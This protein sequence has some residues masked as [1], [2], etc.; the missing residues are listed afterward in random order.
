M[1]RLTRNKAAEMLGVSRQTINNYVKEGLLGGYKDEKGNFYVNGDDVERY[2]KKYKFIAAS[3]KMLDDKLAS[4][5]A[6][7]EKASNELAAFRRKMTGRV[8]NYPSLESDFAGMI[9]TLYKAAFVPKLC[10]RE[11]QLL[12]SFIKGE[13]LKELSEEYGLTF[14]RIRQIIAKACRKFHSQAEEICH[15]MRS[16]EELEL[17]VSRLEQ[18]LELLQG[19]YDAYREA[20]EDSASVSLQPP[21]ILQTKIG[22]CNFSIRVTN[23]LKGYADILTLGELLTE[24]TSL[25]QLGQK[26]RNL[27]RKSLAEIDDFMDAFGLSFKEE[28]ESEVHFYQRLNTNIKND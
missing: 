21:E 15:N 28:N 20:H 8:H 25:Q 19:Q 6:E 14:E 26:T 18:S 13:K 12:T 16:N 10:E 11:R 9:D 24:F 7:R 3:E 27:G 17:K 2:A 5:K 4:L 22:D 23:A 1:N